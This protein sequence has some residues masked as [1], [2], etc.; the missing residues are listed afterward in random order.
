MDKID[1]RQKSKRKEFR[2]TLAVKRATM[3]SISAQEQE[4]LDDAD[5]DEDGYYYKDENDHLVE[6][7]IEKEEEEE[8]GDFHDKFHRALTNL[9]DPDADEIEN[10]GSDSDDNKDEK[11][12]NLIPKKKVVFS[13]Q[14]KESVLENS[15]TENPS[16]P[17]IKSVVTKTESKL[18]DLGEKANLTDMV[19]KIKIEE[20]K[21][22]S[23]FI[24]DEF[25]EEVPIDRFS[26]KQGI[27]EKS[28]TR[29]Y[30][31]RTK[32]KI[33]WSMV[34][35]K[36]FLKKGVQGEES[37][38]EMNF[39][40][41][42]LFIF[43]DAPFDFIRR[44]TIPPADNE[45]WNR[46]IATINPIFS[47]FFIFFTLQI[48]T[49]TKAPPYSFYIAEG[50]ALILSVIIWFTTPL[51]KGPR[52]GMI[53]FS[54]F[55]FL[56]SIMWIWFIAKFLIDLLGVVGLTL[57]FKS[58][59]LGIT[60]L[61][62]GNSV[63]DMM[64]NSAVA[65]NG[66]ARMALTGCFA[67]PLF[68]LLIGLGSSLMVKKINGFP[69]ESFKIDDVDARLPLMAIGGLMIQLVLISLISII[70][71]FKLKKIQGIIQ[72]GYF[73]V[74]LTSITIAAFTFAK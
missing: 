15:T 47:I 36:K 25:Y 30:A 53:L 17:E 38:S 26:Q 12:Q 72:V 42:L 22:L 50:I 3:G 66:L 13:I 57:G 62:W 44:L 1:E 28:S 40:K 59:Y 65:R 18:F 39:F 23:S 52:R 14:N 9:T 37:F 34:K 71:R 68:N 31:S 63:G 54:I 32:H 5:L 16:T 2:K 20:G 4:M 67:G 11:K 64:A 49:F 8:E 74:L 35:M 21:D 73:L 55:G 19:E 58:S 27:F 43:I 7:K 29:M 48:V 45:M 51:N 46:R 69:P 56:L 10:Q 33:V 24:I 41:K 6:I 61:A 60:L 70:S